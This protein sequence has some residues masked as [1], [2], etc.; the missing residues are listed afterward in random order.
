MSLSRRNF[1]RGAGGIAV[2][3]P[4]LESLRRQL[5]PV[6]TPSAASSARVANAATAQKRF[7]TFFNCN[8]V[9]M[10]RFFPAAPYGQLTAN[11]FSGTSCEALAPFA[12]KICWPRGIHMWPRGYNMDGGAGDD[13]MKGMGHKLT[14]HFLQDTSDTYAN[15]I[16]ID[17]AIAKVINPNGAAAMTLKV[18]PH[19][20]GVLGNISY[21]GPGTPVIGE[22]NPWFAYRDFMGIDLADPQLKENLDLRKKSVLDVVK[23]DFDALSQ[24]DLSKA[25]REKLELHFQTIRDL[26]NNM[27]T[28]GLVACSLDAN[29]EAEIKAI[30]P[31]RI[32]LD[33]EFPKMGKLQMDVIALAMACGH[34]NV[35]SL[36]WGD[37]AGGP[38]YNWS[39]MQHTYRHHP[40]SHGTAGD[41]GGDEVIG[42]EDMLAQIDSWHM[43]QFAY[44]L[45]RLNA[46]DEGDGSLLDN[47]VVLYCN[48]LSDGKAHDFQDLPM[49][50]VGGAGYFR[51]GQY[52][53]V[54]NQE[55][56]RNSVDAQHCKLLNMCSNAVGVPSMNFGAPGAPTGELAAIKA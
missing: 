20:S 8:G 33:A 32:G 46:Y 51:V 24:A 12:S 40:L 42:Y 9:Q 39:G 22:N 16:S 48:E 53:K 45:G 29:L 37:G 26:E 14:A 38:V 2:G 13:H 23:A 18:G 3:L 54:T 7:L 55:S 27:N 15:G 19:K 30:D 41:A 4:L 17:Q 25:D 44:L 56:V 21:S 34:S 50:V 10:N 11:S 36:Q 6:L 47:T 49:F 28:A 5:S 52:A 35:A 31:N 43:E 1:L